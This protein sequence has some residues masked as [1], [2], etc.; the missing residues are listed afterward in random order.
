MNNVKKATS[1]KTIFLLRKMLYNTPIMRWSFATYLYDKVF[2][3]GMPDL[4]KPIK[5]RGSDFYIDPNDRSYV[6]TMV[7]GYYE[8]HELDLFEDIVQ[9]S[10]VFLD[11]GANVGMYSVL[12]VNKNSKVKCYAFEPV[13]ENS[14]LLAKNLRANQITDQVTVV[15]KAVSETE[16][17]AT[18]YL[19]AKSSG[20]HSL[21][22]DHGSIKRRVPTISVDK[23]CSNEAIV[24]DLIKIDVE[25]HEPSVFAGM[26][27]VLGNQPTIFME[28]MP[29]VNKK[30]I[31]LITSLKKHYKYCYVVDEIR[32]NIKKYK[33]SD[34]NHTNNHN[35]ILCANKQHMQLIDSVISSRK[36][37]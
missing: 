11:I 24:P 28:Y 22:I 29:K 7:A 23:F 27:K 12:A 1:E 15:K 33:L 6:P 17:I 4:T 30:M 37:S 9:R 21:A 8:K 3:L 18:I 26:S 14:D 32:G 31:G 13:K 20:M 16:G 35:L 19:D 5:F 36:K 2:S 25:G 34:I 10:K